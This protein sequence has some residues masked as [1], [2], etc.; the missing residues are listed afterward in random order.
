LKTRIERR[1]KK[2]VSN[3]PFKTLETTDEII[4]KRVSF[5]A[6]NEAQNDLFKRLRTLSIDLSGGDVLSGFEIMVGLTD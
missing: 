6:I 1:A 3:L 2:R 5:T 4:P